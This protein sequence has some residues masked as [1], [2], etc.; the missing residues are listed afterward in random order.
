MNQTRRDFLAAVGKGM[1][2][3]SVGPALAA[4]LGLHSVRADESSEEL[5]FGKLE[6]L[7]C[8]MQET[9]AQKLLPLVVEKLGT[10]TE[11]KEILATAALAN[12]RSFGGE[13]YVGFHTMMA[14]APAY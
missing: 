4:D 6:P 9:P 11:L 13:D 2:I 14:L 7:V 10:G 8:L 3:A 5:N 12:A 1:L